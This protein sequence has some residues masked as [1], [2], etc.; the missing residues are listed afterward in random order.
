MGS[1]LDHCIEI[2]LGCPHE[3]GEGPRNVQEWMQS[4]DG[5]VQECRGTAWRR[6]FGCGLA[7]TSAV[8]ERDVSGFGLTLMNKLWNH[9]KRNV[10][11]G[12]DGNARNERS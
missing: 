6:P 1:S 10:K 9:Q 3:K 2:L 4:L 8:E 12:A 7:M 11:G 5:L